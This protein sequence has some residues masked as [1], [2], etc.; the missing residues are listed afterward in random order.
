MKIRA[1]ADKDRT[2]TLAKAYAQAEKIRGAAEAEA[3]RVY[4]EA[5][6][7]DPALYELLR[8]LEAYQKFLDEK[9]T[10]LLSAD[11]DVLKYLTQGPPIEG[12]SAGPA[13]EGPPAENAGESPGEVPG[14]DPAESPEN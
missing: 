7:Q 12:P 4:A 9:T 3:T 6:R 14:E 8:T 11:S 10:V 2:V 1:T 5:H 13:L